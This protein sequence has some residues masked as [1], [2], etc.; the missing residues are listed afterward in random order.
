MSIKTFEHGKLSLWQSAIEEV[1][2]KRAAAALTP[3]ADGSPSLASRI[4]IDHP[5]VGGAVI[6][7]AAKVLDNIV[8]GT[9]A[10]GSP[11]PDLGPE[12]LAAYFSH[13]HFEL[14][15][16]KLKLD[17][18]K[19]PEE[20]A[21]IENEIK[22][23]EEKLGQFT[24]TDPH[25]AEAIEKYL[26]YYKSLGPQTVPYVRW[27]NLDE[28]VI[29][30]LPENAT[31][32]FIA[33]WGTGL[34][35][36]IEVLNQVAAANPDVV[37]HLGDI[38]YSGTD[39][40]IA[41]CFL[42]PISRSNLSKNTPVYSIPGN[43]E[44]YAGG[45]PYYKMLQA[46]GHGQLASYFCLRNKD[47]QF[48]G[49]DTGLN[50]HDPFTVSTK[51]TFLDPQEVVW[52]LDKINNNGNRRTVLLSHHEPFSA[53]S[54]TAGQYVNRALLGAFAGVLDK[55]S[56]WLW[57]H[58]HA[59]YI[60]QP[61]EGVQRGRCIGNGAIPVSDDQKPYEAL[62]DCDIKY[63]PNKIGF[64]EALYANGYAIMK[65]DGPKA[66]ICYYQHPSTEGDNMVYSETIE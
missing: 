64:G 66:E 56:L 10:D 1:I 61:Y 40:E 58:E 21:A 37:I 57:G 17:F 39:D 60:Y 42:D 18:A 4:A 13:L 6:H 33:D 25:W 27:A 30:T 26:E 24:V 46:M 22:T 12:Q 36:S 11:D 52:H 41:R 5:L 7:A 14:A 62:A 8:P 45:Q 47:W 49:M 59:M 23:Y 16:A 19:D 29:D 38:Y 50:D 43:H 28:F 55:I 31:V 9:T 48:L 63:E 35:A 32:G 15:E 54:R 20:R 51:Q 53:F 44:M 2:F 65:L 3:D 34:Q